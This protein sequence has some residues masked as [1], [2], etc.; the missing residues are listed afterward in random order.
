MHVDR[1][2]FLMFVTSLAVGGAGG[3]VASEKDLVPHLDGKPPRGATPPPAPSASAGPP[4]PAAAPDAATEALAVD[5]G[6]ACDDSVGE[7]EACPPPGLPTVEGGCGGFATTRCNDFKRTMKP[8]VA[9]AAVACLLKLTPA[10]RCDPKRVD[11]CAHLALMNACEDTSPVSTALPACDAIVEA[12]ASTPVPPSKAECRRSMAGLK[13]IGRE[14]MVDCA[15]KH[16]FDRGI[17]GCEAAS[18]GKP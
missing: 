18:P 10:Q 15:R 8:R 2:A 13:E 16:C 14:A 12:C 1:G 5:A 11:L 17:L 3:Y 4:P 9:Q 6:P 7:P